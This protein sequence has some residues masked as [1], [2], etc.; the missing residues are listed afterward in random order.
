[1]RQHRNRFY[2]WLH[3]SRFIGL[4][5]GLIPGLI[6]RIALGLVLSFNAAQ[7]AEPLKTKPSA[8]QFV[9]IVIDDL[10]NHRQDAAVLDIDAPLTVGVLPHTPQAGFIVRT[11]AARNKEIIVHL[12]MQAHSGSALGPGALTADMTPEAFQT[13]LEAALASMPQAVGVNNHMGSLLTERTGAMQQLMHELARRNLYFIDSRTSLATVAETVAQEAGVKH[14]RRH[15]FLDNDRRRE[16]LDTQF[17]ALIRH[18]KKHGSAI[19]IGHPYPETVALLKRRLPE[20][21][22]QGIQVV[23]VSQLTPK[24]TPQQLNSAATTSHA[25]KSSTTK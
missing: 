7:A 5:L 13:T 9:A 10:G 3:A 4:A 20:L 24:L 19:A 6:P 11:A 17:N 16:S 1:M 25:L 21:A 23:P 8:T 22:A 2:T 18:A 12:P 15:V 14:Y